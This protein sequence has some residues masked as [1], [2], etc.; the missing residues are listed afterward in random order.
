MFV[1]NIY[2]SVDIIGSNR[3]LLSGE[4]V[5][6][7]NPTYMLYIDRKVKKFRN[8]YLFGDQVSINETA[9]GTNLSNTSSY[10]TAKLF[11]S[12]IIFPE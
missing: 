8:L 5:L 11:I 2:S 4:M 12:N 1:V 10:L 7:W 9:F 6:I 3:Y